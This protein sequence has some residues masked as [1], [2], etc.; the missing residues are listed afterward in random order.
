MAQL[1]LETPKA[2]IIHCGDP[3]FQK[4]FRE[5]KSRELGLE[6]GQ[7]IPLIVPGSVA[8][9]CVGTFLPKNLKI[10][11]EQIELLLKHYPTGRVI[12]IN[13]EGCRS[14]GAM[15]AKLQHLIASSIGARQVDDLKFAAG[16]IREIARHYGAQ[17]NVEMYMARVRKE[18]GEIVFE[19]VHAA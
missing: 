6:E 16:M 5:F 1:N 12:L 15:A 7:Y 8:S 13:H 4:A 2:L 3:K 14:Y 9:L 10:M 18:D 19:R 17:V 11:R